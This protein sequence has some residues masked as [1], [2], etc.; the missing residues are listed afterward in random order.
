M[1]GANGHLPPAQL[2][3]RVGVDGIGTWPFKPLPVP[4]AAPT[5]TKGTRS[6]PQSFP[7]E[8]ACVSHCNPGPRK[9]ERRQRTIGRKRNEKRAKSHETNRSAASRHV[10]L[11]LFQPCGQT[12]SALPGLGHREVGGEREGTGNSFTRTYCS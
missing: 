3:C 11:V 4:L 5:L 8:R 7:E 9:C 1:P 2:P 12:A 10:A 6:A